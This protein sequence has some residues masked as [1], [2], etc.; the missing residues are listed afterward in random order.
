MEDHPGI[1]SRLAGSLAI[2]SS[3]V[4]DAKTFTSRDGIAIF[5]FWIQDSY[6]DPYN[7]SKIKKLLETVKNSLTGK[8]VTKS[9]LD[10]RD[11]ITERERDFKV[12][13]KVLF[14]NQGSQNQ[15]IIEVDTRDR[16]GLLF[17]LTNTLFRN[18]VTIRSAVIATYGEQAVDTFYVNDLFGDKIISNSKLEKLEKELLFSLEKNYEKAI[19]E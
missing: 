17:D 12:P 8:F 6:G 1:F 5:I 11:K 2:A 9:I 15:T 7:E 13:T 19:K 14:D 3:S 16:V 10:K 18:Q 4:I